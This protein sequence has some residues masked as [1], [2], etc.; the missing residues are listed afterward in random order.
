[1]EVE[2][3]YSS[4]PIKTRCNS[5]QHSVTLNSCSLINNDSFDSSVINCCVIILI[6]LIE[7]VFPVLE[8]RR[9]IKHYLCPSFFLVS[10]IAGTE[11]DE[12]IIE[13]GSFIKSLEYV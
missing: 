11:I 8:I 1:M 6:T 5:T 7:P 10:S 13:F 9:R 4:F 2:V 12:N 3:E